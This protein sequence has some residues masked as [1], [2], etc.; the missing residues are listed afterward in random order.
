M[1]RRPPT[2]PT[3]SWPAWP[4]TFDTGQL[5]ISEYGRIRLSRNPAAKSPRPEPSTTATSGTGARR[6]LRKSV[7]SLISLNPMSSPLHEGLARARPVNGF[8]EERKALGTFVPQLNC[9]GQQQCRHFHALRLP[10]VDPQQR[11]THLDRRANLTDDIDPHAQIHDIVHLV[12]AGAERDGGLADESGIAR[13]KYPGTVSAHKNSLI[14]QR[15]QVRLID[16]ARV[17]ALGFDH[18]GKLLKAAAG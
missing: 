2:P 8:N 14:G 10:E 6:W 3:T 9:R 5:G 7:V 11:I 15:Q 18:L 13:G 1:T 17:A 4:M 12:A 16:D